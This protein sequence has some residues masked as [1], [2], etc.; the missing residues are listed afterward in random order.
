MVIKGRNGVSM[1]AHEVNFD[2]LVGPSHNYAGLS[3]GN[4]ASTNN[5]GEVSNPRLAALQGLEKAKTLAD[6]GL[7]QGVFAPHVRPHFQVLKELG[8]SGS[9][10][11]IIEKAFKK[12]PE[13][14]AACY[15]SS[16]MWTANAATVSPSA[17]TLD[18]KVH[19]TPANL[20]NKFHRSIEPHLTGEIL[21]AT[22]KDSDKFVHHKPLPQTPSFGDEG[23]ANHTRFCSDYENPGVEFFVFGRYGLVQNKPEP[24]VFPARQ[25]LEA[26]QAIARL[27]GLDEKKTVF[28]QQKPG[29]IDQ[30][31][32]HNDVISVGNKNVYFYHEEA[33]LEEQK[34]KDELLKAL[35]SDFHFIKVPTDKV[36]VQD[37]VESYLF[38][39][40]LLSF[41][42]DKMAI[43]VPEECRKNNNVWNYLQE[44]ISEDHYVKEVKVFDVTES[45]KNGGGPACLRLRVVLT[46]DEL[47]CVNPKTLLDD[48]LYLNLTDWVKKHYRDRLKPSDLSDPK[49][50]TEIRTALD[51]LTQIMNLGSVYDFQKS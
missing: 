8:F 25:T 28:A 11:E 6:L 41:S 26:S 22:F 46:E 19:F 43:V 18:K 30:G 35:G 3:K 9:E 29:V 4:I 15:S 40:Q 34:T 33:L 32:F 44:L 51:E 31:V 49:L 20:N 2:G 14:L 27:H 48:K 50:P 7:K 23:A 47:K 5:V 10:T 1:K 36:S 37:A 38:N 13:I 24:K 12:A 42:S 21:K 39:S 45:M 17:D 16:A